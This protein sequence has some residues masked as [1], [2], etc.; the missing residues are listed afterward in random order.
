MTLCSASNLSA[1]FAAA[2][3]SSTL[4]ANFIEVALILR[5]GLVLRSN[6]KT[7]VESTPPLSAIDTSLKL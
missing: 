4:F 1:I 7:N 2:G 5:S 6:D 3:V